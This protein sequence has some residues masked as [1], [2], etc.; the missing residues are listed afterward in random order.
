MP[1]I[2]SF[3]P[4]T[5]NAND[6]YHFERDNIPLKNINDRIELINF[7]VDQIAD[8]VRDSI[9]NAGTLQ[10]RL[11]QSLESNGDLKA[12]A[13]DEAEHSIES[14]TDTDN[15]V[16]M[17]RAQS[18]KLN[19]VQVDAN[20]LKVKVVEENA[21]EHT[22]ETNV[23]TAA[24]SDSIKLVV[25][26]QVVTWETVFD[27]AGIH[28]HY[29]NITPV[30]QDLVDPDYINYKVAN[31]TEPTVFIAGSL[32]VTINGVRIFEGQ[33][34]YVPGAT[35]DADWKLIK[36]TE[37]AAAGTFALSTAITEDDVIRIDFDI[38]LT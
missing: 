23:M 5:Y 3:T 15:Y 9:G 2:E 22:F 24:S 16:R 1:R 36:F 8:Q 32:R 19:S 4:I 29:Y 6:P 25:N 14:H 33:K 27:T 10:N 17:T 12:S 37:N 26:G 21:T 34:V 38:A 28:R 20:N 30:D 13:I 18:D 31:T 7:T 35:L 11:N